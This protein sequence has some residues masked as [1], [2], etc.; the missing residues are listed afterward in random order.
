MK[1]PDG[2]KKT[3]KLNYTS[4]QV[5]A[6]LINKAANASNEAYFGMDLLRSE[7]ERLINNVVDI[8]QGNFFEIIERTKFN[9]DA[10]SKGM[11]ERAVT[12]AEMGLWKDPVDIKIKAGSKVL[13]EVQAKSS[14]EAMCALFEMS[15][16]KYEVMQN[17]FNSDKVDKARELV[18]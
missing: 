17:L 4:A 11:G 12:T 15:N 7:G 10:A 14:R 18:E 6:T 2:R 16:E 5:S 1:G 13:R 3:D 9:V 8:K